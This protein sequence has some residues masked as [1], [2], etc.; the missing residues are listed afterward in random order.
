M[1]GDA[2]MRKKE[3]MRKGKKS[4]MAVLAAAV[5]ANS[6]L[7]GYVLAAGPETEMAE[8]A[9]KTAE[10]QKPTEKGAGQAAS[11]NKGNA[12]DA[13]V[14]QAAEQ[15]VKTA[16]EI[17]KVTE[18]PKPQAVEV[19]AEPQMEAPVQTEMPQA[20]PQTETPVQTGAPQMEPQT[21][22]QTEAPQTERQTEAPQTELQTER[23][24]ETQQTESETEHQTEPLQTE[25][26][27]EPQTEPVTETE[28]EAESEAETETES[29]SE[30]EALSEE[31]QALQD[32]IDALPTVEEFKEMTDGEKVED[33]N[34]TQEQYDIY[35]EA[36]DICDEYDALSEEDQALLD[37]TKLE[38]LME[39]FNEAM[40]QAADE[41]GLTISAA[42][43]DKG[44]W[45]IQNKGTKEKPY[46]VT[47]D[48]AV[49]L[50]GSGSAVF[51]I[52][53]SCVQFTG[54][55]GAQITS[56]Q[57]TLLDIS[58]DSNVTVGALGMTAKGADIYIKN[59]GT[60]TLAGANITYSS[61]S[62]G[63]RS[64]GLTDNSGTLIVNGGL[65]KNDV[66]GRKYMFLG[67]NIQILSGTLEGNGMTGGIGGSNVTVSGGEIKNFNIGIRCA[68][69]GDLLR[70]GG[71]AKF[72][73]SNRDVFY[74]L[75]AAA[76]L[77]PI[78]ID[79]GFTGT[80]RVYFESG[81]NK[82]RWKITAASTDMQDPHYQSRLHLE[83]ANP[84][85]YFV[86]YWPGKYW[87]TSAHDDSGHTW[88]YAENGNN[89]TV[90]C[91]EENCPY[92]NRGG[93]VLSVN[94]AGGIYNGEP[95]GATVSNDITAATGATAVLT[96][97][98]MQADGTA[99]GPTAEAPTNAGSYKAVVT[100][101]AGTAIYTAEQGFEITKIAS[102]VTTVPTVKQDLTYDG[103]LHDLITAGS[104]TDGT[105]E[106]S[107]DGT[108]WS[109]S[110]PQAKDAGNYTIYYRVV[111]DDANYTGVAATRLTE[112]AAI[113]QRPAEIIADP[114]GKTY[115]ATDPQ[116]TWH[117]EDIVAQ[118]ELG[119]DDIAITREAGEDAGTYTIAASAKDTANKNYSYTFKSAEFTINKAM[120]QAPAVQ[121]ADETIKGRGDGKLTGLT[122]AMEYRVESDT[123]YTAVT[124][125]EVTDL[126]PGTYYVR[127]QGDPNHTA[128]PDT[129]AVIAEGKLA[130]IILPSDQKGYTLTASREEAAWGEEVLLTLTLAPGYSKTENF[131]LKVN[132]E[133][134]TLGEDNTCT[135]KDIEADA[136]ITVEGVADITAP[137]IIGVETDGVYTGSVTFTV[138]DEYLTKVTVDG[139]PVFEDDGNAAGTTA[140]NAESESNTGSEDNRETSGFN[141]LTAVIS[142]ATETEA[143]A[144]D[145]ET[146]NGVQTL[147]ATENTKGGAAVQTVHTFTLI[148]K[149]GTYRIGA[150]D[151]SGN[152]AVAANITVNWK[153]VQAPDGGSKEY[154]GE[155]LTSDL[156][157]GTIGEASYTV[158]ENTGGT[159]AGNYDVKLTLTDPVNYKWENEEGGKA[160]TV[161]TF[162][163][164]PKS[165][166][167]A[168]VVLGPSLRANGSEQTQTVEKVVLDGKELPADVYTVENNT[169]TE[170]GIY[171][172][173]V[174]A[175]DGSNYT[176][177]VQKEFE[178]L[179]AETETETETETPVETETETETEAPVETETETETPVETETET[180]T[181]VETETE[182]ESE[183]QK[184]SE[185][186]KQTE[187]NKQTPTSGTTPRTG[188]TTPLTGYAVVC[189][190]SL[191]AA[192]L[193]HGGRKKF[194]R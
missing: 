58:G 96:Y 100:L 109:E 102:A 42:N 89:I 24:T 92:Y 5:I 8:E 77:E 127:Y 104:A 132:G 114:A 148:P 48:G 112:E 174:R 69:A 152:S 161:V 56:D 90:A 121:A 191:T 105:L 83:S 151:A 31:L 181:P 126:A 1:K 15:E 156:T 71:T 28:S 139:E 110:V 38:A 170:P 6:A 116:L 135:L 163:I 10:S 140:G 29:E 159:D 86:Y 54:K 122:A 128:S 40:L 117:T 3:L 130:Q 176:G 175:K 30:T 23:Q 16:V 67:G 178:I 184:Q 149:T 119:E 20:E 157:D 187:T 72:S 95:Y 189:I 36:Q 11:E 21:E 185:T 192:M 19:Q 115:G 133:A 76:S 4:L 171:T 173:T 44:P 55:N 88:N 134:V 131:A 172:L 17:E 190:L 18:A 46:V 97:S 65:Y 160:D 183:T 153:E 118:A 87:C 186:K 94:A 9:E 169:A 99:Y 60:L 108:N 103:S 124:G 37:I 41:N 91:E 136:Q 78:Q 146:G 137:Q 129:T 75:A 164:T 113:D 45:V 32:R 84:V 142:T 107:L 106:Y 73:S 101:T 166:A 85:Y 81:M 120:Q 62:V 138:E 145:T 194:R 179:E 61:D 193:L 13:A 147:A 93:A 188:D 80:L 12:K 141:A 70:I 144:A 27:T 64:K 82:Y 150:S 125:E 168:E 66:S 143:A 98:G 49:T 68:K 47:I 154:T 22:P 7:P 14:P 155:T 167:D 26:E 74:S 51:Q 34:F 123:S 182:S 165:I 35:M 43:Q 39:Y 25:S 111:S 57:G 59:A 50:N 52:K 177:E 33:T 53:G 79:K 180:E 158:T 2:G 162:A 63:D